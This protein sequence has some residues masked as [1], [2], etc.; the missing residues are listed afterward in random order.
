MNFFSSNAAASVLYNNVGWHANRTV[1]T[2]WIEYETAASIYSHSILNLHRLIKK[3]KLIYINKHRENIYN[4]NR[5]KN[6]M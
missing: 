4:L 3:K 1:E 5:G 2:S 6:S